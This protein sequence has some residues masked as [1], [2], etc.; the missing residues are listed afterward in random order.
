M[1]S[2]AR[3]AHAHSSQSLPFSLSSMLRKQSKPGR[4][5]RKGGPYPV[6]SLCRA[7]CCHSS[8]TEPTT[9]HPSVRPSAG[10]SIRPSLRLGKA[11]K[12]ARVVSGGRPWEGGR[13]R[14][15]HFTAES[16]SGGGQ[17]EAEDIVLSRPRHSARKAICKV[18]GLGKTLEMY[19]R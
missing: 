19:P 6:Q 17:T 18:A 12:A 3:F 16:I 8:K 10:L 15:L 13:R 7:L 2:L 11:L 4:V 5:W 1:N 9:D 14:R